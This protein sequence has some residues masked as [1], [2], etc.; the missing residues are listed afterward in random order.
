[1]DRARR[2]R[3]TARGR[4]RGPLWLAIALVLAGCGSTI[5]SPSAPT[6]GSPAAVAGTPAPGGSASAVGAPTPEPGE[7]ARIDVVSCPAERAASAPTHPPV[8]TTMTATVTPDIA[9]MVSFYSSG[10]LTV[11]GPKDWRCTATVG[12]DGTARMAITPPAA[13]L[14]TAPATAPPDAQAVTAVQ[15]TTCVDCLV[16]MTCAF[17]PEAARLGSGACAS[18][19]P[20]GEGVRRSMPRAVVFEDAPGTAGSGEPSG[21]TQRAVG[22]IVF[23]PGAAA[24]GSRFGPSALKITCAL[25]ASMAAVC[26]EIVE[27]R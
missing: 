6:S 5:P 20:P 7:V 4:I 22:L 8:P 10:E 26:D 1:M 16:R 2:E 25:P 11:L 15:A 9:A 19:I 18:T 23:D 17:F 14:P 13:P 27:Q 24:G 12:P 21:G 3:W